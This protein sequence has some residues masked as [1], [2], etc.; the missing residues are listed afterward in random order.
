MSDKIKLVVDVVQ[1]RPACALVQ[2]AY[3]IPHSAPILARFDP[4][5]WLLAPTDDMHLVEGTM[6]QWHS[7]ADEC[8]NRGKK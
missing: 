3:G 6:E 2:A 1:R 7:F 8:N 5:A 4:G